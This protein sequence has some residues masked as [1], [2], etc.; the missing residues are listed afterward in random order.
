M[1]LCLRS[2]LQ[3]LTSAKCDKVYVRLIELSDIFIQGLK[4]LNFFCSTILLGNK[5]HSMLLVMFASPATT[6][7]WDIGVCFLASEAQTSVEFSGLT[8]LCRDMR[9]HIPTEFLC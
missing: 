2:G 5:C 7:V 3:S 8:L 1:T 4:P 6:R 9:H